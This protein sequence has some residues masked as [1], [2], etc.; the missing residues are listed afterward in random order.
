MPRELPG[1]CARRWCCEAEE[2]LN[3]V[4]KVQASV[5]ATSL[6]T[7]SQHLCPWEHEDS[8]WGAF[9]NLGANPASGISTEAPSPFG[10][11]ALR[12]WT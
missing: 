7:H 9:H 10:G 1:G 5:A 2:K 4:L 8:I 3:S 6:Q 11:P 12:Q